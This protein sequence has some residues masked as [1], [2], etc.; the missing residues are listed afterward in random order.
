MVKGQDWNSV[1]KKGYYPRQAAPFT[2][3][4]ILTA[5][6]LSSNKILRF[7]NRGELDRKPQLLNLKAPFSF[8]AKVS[9]SRRRI[10]TS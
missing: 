9:T 3:G 8:L 4:E 10:N 5:T 7:K 1:R 2:N 6:F